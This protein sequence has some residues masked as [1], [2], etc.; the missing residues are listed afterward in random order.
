MTRLLPEPPGQVT[1]MVPVRDAVALGLASSRAE[2]PDPPVMVVFG[3]GTMMWI[4]PSTAATDQVQVGAV[5]REKSRL[6]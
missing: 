2:T 6:L 4:Q 5:C 1:V 3:V